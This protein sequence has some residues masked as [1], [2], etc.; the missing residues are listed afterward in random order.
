[1]SVP[2]IKP[3]II[4]FLGGTQRDA[5]DEIHFDQIGEQAGI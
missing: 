3:K 1:V 5:G 2:V 4:V